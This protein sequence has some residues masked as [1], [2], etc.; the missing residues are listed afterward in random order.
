MKRILFVDDEP[1]VLDALRNVLRK[2]RDEWHMVFAPGGEEALAEL[3]AATFDVI[4][5][6][7]RMP[8]LDGASLLHRVK[9]LYP[10]T[11]RIVLSGHAEQDMVMKVLP[12]AHQYLTKPCDRLALRAAIDQACLLQVQLADVATRELVG[13][14]ESLP[15]VPRTYV[16]LT[17]TLADEDAGVGDVSAIVE[18]DPAL[19]AKVLQIANS[20]FFGRGKPVSS[21]CDGVNFLGLDLIRALSLMVGI[22][23][24]TEQHH[25]VDGMR[26][27]QLQHEAVLVASIAR[28]IVRERGR[29]DEAY[30]VGVLH[31]VGK[32]IFLLRAPDHYADVIRIAEESGRRLQEV[33]F[34]HFGTTHAQVGAFLL[35]TW[36]LPYDVVQAVAYHHTPNKA[37][38]VND[39]L[40][41]AVHVAAGLVSASIAGRTDIGW[42][43][44]V[45]LLETIGASEW[46]EQSRA[47]V[48]DMLAPALGRS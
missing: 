7:M 16:E 18:R 17:N 3:A 21:I 45:A 32:Y 29:R 5:T 28:R 12:M 14:I 4:V 6:D 23:G 15:S 13:D 24:S 20:A 41:T 40:I 36:G 8:R 27:E 9:A 25:G 31:D 38:F 33:E 1:L 22:F 30:A 46:F 11:A 10:G 47:I 35:D 19:S 26:I 42:F 37:P 2:H 43:V 34:E 48:D 39:A 44:D